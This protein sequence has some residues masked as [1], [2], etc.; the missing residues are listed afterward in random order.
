M[1]DSTRRPGARTP[2]DTVT[3]LRR[4]VEEVHL[5]WDR[6]EDAES[7]V[8]VSASQLRVLWVLERT[9][10]LNLRELGEAVG[11]APSALSRLCA[12]LEAMG[13]VRRLPSAQSGREIELH[14]THQAAVYLSERRER[15]EQVLAALLDAMPPERIGPLADGVAA[16]R[17]ILD[18]LLEAQGAVPGTH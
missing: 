18:A 10:G 14:L 11:S 3:E 9:P 7:M 12:R 2:G 16:L 8:V 13:F 15:R 1:G 4:V 5:L 6:S 17:P